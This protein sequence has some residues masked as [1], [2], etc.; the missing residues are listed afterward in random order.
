[1]TPPFLSE[2]ISEVSSVGGPNG[3]ADGRP[4]EIIILI[5]FLTDRTECPLEVIAAEHD[6]E[7]VRHSEH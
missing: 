5:D 7:Q 4:G 1:M 2:P 6:D 3:R